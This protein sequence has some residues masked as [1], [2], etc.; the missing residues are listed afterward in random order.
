[1]ETS[2]HV[3]PALSEMPPLTC[4]AKWK[5]DPEDLPPPGAAGD[6][7]DPWLD[8]TPRPEPLLLVHFFPF[9]P[10]D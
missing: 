8:A 2:C 3:H 5:D 4:R 10:L 1:M 9:F 6:R 7:T